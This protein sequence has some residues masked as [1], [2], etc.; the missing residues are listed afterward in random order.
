[1]IRQHGRSFLKKG[2]GMDELLNNVYYDE[3]SPTCLRWKVTQK[4]PDGRKT[5]CT[6]NSVVGCKNAKVFYFKHKCYSIVKTVLL[7]HGICFLN[8]VHHIKYKDKNTRNFRIDNIL[9]EVQQKVQAKEKSKL[10]K[11]KQL[12]NSKNIQERKLLT[13]ARERA[14]RLGI[15]CTIVVEDIVIPKICPILNIEIKKGV[16]KSLPS[17]PTL[18]RINPEIGYVK[19]NIQVISRKANTM[20]SDATRE[21]LLIFANW[22][23]N[24]NN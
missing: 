5:R 7:L 2:V 8:N 24:G 22:V 4:L 18:D 14:R 13:S 23:L 11:E 15:E 3:T 9:C 1:M 16:K 20:K 21:E 17:S 12:K 10:Y 19:G 6:E